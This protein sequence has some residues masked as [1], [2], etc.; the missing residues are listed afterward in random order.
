ML[1]RLGLLAGALA[2]TPIV[3]AQI[4]FSALD[5]WRGLEAQRGP[6]AK[7]EGNTNSSSNPTTEHRRHE[8]TQKEM[9]KAREQAEQMVATIR[10]KLSKPGPAAA[11][12]WNN[13][14]MSV[15]ASR[16]YLDTP[17][18]PAGAFA[19]VA[20]GAAGTH[21][22]LLTPLALRRSA[23]I[24]AGAVTYNSS[25]A[26][27]GETAAFLAEEAATAMQGGDLRVRVDDAAF[28]WNH[29]REEQFRALLQ[30]AEESFRDIAFAKTE[31]ARVAKEAVTITQ[32][33]QQGTLS[34]EKAESMKKELSDALEAALKRSSEAQQKIQEL[35]KRIE[36]V[37]E[38]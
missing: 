4:D 9:Q 16:R 11:V 34:A 12:T 24:L 17:P 6:V 28:K 1:V 37:V 2:C 29:Q 5:K 35:P 7:P 30:D 25:S 14:S 26:D 19:A 36:I 27:A 20:A 3:H 38:Q 18:T 15:A 13:T 21:A 8:P 23:A 31:Q 22:T 32:S 33:V 10:E